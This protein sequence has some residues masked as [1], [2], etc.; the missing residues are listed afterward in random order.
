MFSSVFSIER[1]RV[2]AD[3]AH[4]QERLL[5]PRLARCPSSRARACRPR[6][7]RARSARSDRRAPCRRSRSSTSSRRCA[8]SRRTRR[9]CWWSSRG[10]RASSPCRTGRRASDASRAAL[11]FVHRAGAV[12]LLM[13]AGVGEE[14][15]D[16]FRLGRDHALDGFGVTGLGHADSVCIPIRL[17]PAALDRPCDFVPRPGLRICACAAG[18]FQFGCDL[19]PS[20]ARATSFR[21][22][23][24]GSAPVP[25]AHSSAATCGPRSQ[26]ATS[27][28]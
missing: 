10:R 16:R 2:L 6:R 1:A 4:A 19:R 17:R 8:G 24:S 9:P 5:G 23:A 11:R 27:V 7:A 18:A 14:R 22:R 20:I 15:E 25:Q 12:D 21:V 26:R 13:T 3:H 28:Y